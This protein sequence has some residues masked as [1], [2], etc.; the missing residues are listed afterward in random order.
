MFAVAAAGGEQ[1]GLNHN[2]RK[3]L[4]TMRA[5]R[6]SRQALTAEECAAV[7]ERNTAGVLAVMGDG[8][9]PYAVPLSYVW[10]DGRLYFH[11]AVSGHKLDAIRADGRASFCVVDQDQII[12]E[13]Y[14]TYYRSVIVFGTARVLDGPEEKRRAI[15]ALGA[16]Y[17]PGFEAE[18][19]AEIDGS[20]DRFLMV[21]L[22]PREITGK[23][24]RELMGGR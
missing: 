11:S 19:A 23:Q 18:L 1:N 15:E 21:E 10:R 6:R 20:W 17:R 16:K 9:W 3:G 8:G 5:M 24:A 7:L 12:P 13:E 22:V 2:H 14:T 4:D